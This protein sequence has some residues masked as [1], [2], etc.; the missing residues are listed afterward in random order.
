MEIADLGLFFKKE[1]ILIVGDFHLGYEESLNKEGLLIPRQQFDM[2]IDRLKNIFEKTG[3]LNKIII[4]GDLKHEFGRISDSE[5]TDCFK[6]IDF[7]NEKCDE[8]VLVKG[9][10]DCVLKAIAK[11]KNLN[12][13]E[14]FK[15]GDNFVCHGDDVFDFSCKR[16]IIGHEHP[17]LVLREGSRVEKYK[18]FLLGKYMGCDL[19]VMPSFNLVQIGADILRNYNEISGTSKIFDKSIDVLTEKFLSPYLSDIGDFKI[20]V[21]ENFEILDF[22]KVR[23]FVS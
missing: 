11:K 15:F 2:T 19:V 5:W 16:I 13:A 20:K 10:H 3:R 14:Y 12:V 17:A 6:L 8:L 18:C 9:N 1:K 23:D 4:N 22:G 7:L 21:V